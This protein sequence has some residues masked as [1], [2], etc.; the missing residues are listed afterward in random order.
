MIAHLID[1]IKKQY[2]YIDTRNTFYPTVGFIEIHHGLNKLITINGI[3]IYTF[4]YHY[5]VSIRNLSI[6]ESGYDDSV[7]I[8]TKNWIFKTKSYIKCTY[9]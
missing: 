1:H 3:N 2:N 4:D 8:K 6:S 5:N 9:W 7:I